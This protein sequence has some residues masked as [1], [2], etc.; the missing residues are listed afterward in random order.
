MQNHGEKEE[1]GVRLWERPEQEVVATVSAFLAVGSFF[2]HK[3][4]AQQSA[5]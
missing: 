3:P 2:G 4:S 5:R 1:S